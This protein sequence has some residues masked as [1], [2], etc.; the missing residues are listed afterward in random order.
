MTDEQLDKFT[1]E[2]NRSMGQTKFLLN[3]LDGDFRKLVDLEERVKNLFLSYCPGD[4]EE[5]EKVLS[6]P[7]PKDK[8][9]SLEHWK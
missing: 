4:K 7:L 5:C 3:L 6:M 8:W 2:T 1:N 9:F